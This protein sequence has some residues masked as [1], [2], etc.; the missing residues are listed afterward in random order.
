MNRALRFFGHPVRPVVRPLFRRALVKFR[1]RACAAII[2]PLALRE[3]DRGR[4]AIGRLLMPE[5]SSR[6]PAHQ[7]TRVF[8]LPSMAPVARH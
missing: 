8:A 6:Y 4:F 3:L 7:T 2:D 5:R 1:A